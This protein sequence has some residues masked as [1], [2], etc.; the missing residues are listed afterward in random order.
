MAMPIRFAPW[1]Q[2]L[3]SLRPG[4]DERERLTEGG[5]NENTVPP[6]PAQVFEALPEN[7]KPLFRHCVDHRLS[8]SKTY[9]IMSRDPL[10]QR[11]RDVMAKQA[12]RKNA[13]KTQDG[14]DTKSHTRIA[15]ELRIVEWRNEW[16]VK[17]AFPF[18]YQAPDGMLRE[19]RRRYNLDGIIAPASTEIQQMMLLREWVHTRWKHGWNH[20]TECK[21]ALEILEAAEK[22]ADFNCG[23]FA[24]TL[25]QCFL[26]LG[27][28]A[29]T[30]VAS[31][32][33]S[34]WTAEDEGNIGHSLTE[35]WSHQF[36]KWVL[37]D[38]DMNV[39]YERDGIPLNALE[40]HRAWVTRRWNEVTMVQGPTP[41][42][43]TESKKSGSAITFKN[44][45]NEAAELWIFSQHN[46]GDYYAHVN[47]LLGNDRHSSDELP[48]RIEWI[49]EWTPQRL[50]GG[51][52]VNAVSFTG[53]EHDV[54]W[55]VDQVQID[56]CCDPS[57]WEQ[58]EAV[59]HVKL[60]HSMPNLDRRL[61]RIDDEPWW[62]TESEFTW[63]LRPGKSQIMAK[64][65]NSFGREG[66]IS[67]I[68]LRF[69]P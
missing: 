65:I 21:N 33:A 38:A 30:V 66:H 5:L 17:S 25:M 60:E 29:R 57:A 31:K 22:G 41:Y 24:T 4:S 2:N 69:N 40:I 46:V 64:G 1:W 32:T 42:H 6:V 10:L 55:T 35:V 12:E 43:V 11:R 36:H 47:Y 67:R 28:V 27:F 7:V 53:N 23:Y 14:G 39:H 68:L 34:E 16:I 26:A 37:H 50:V 3:D 51:K 56:L 48:P 54:N 49:D 9:R 44:P 59:L 62:Q 61:V 63:R 19:L 20:K 8:S 13:S 52:Q 15:P 58:R 18:R 45:D